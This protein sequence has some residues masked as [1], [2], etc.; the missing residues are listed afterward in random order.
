MGK[1]KKVVLA[2][3]GGLDTS[4]IFRGLK[5]ITVTARLLPFVQMSV[6]RVSLT[7]LRKGQRRAEL[8]SF[9]LKI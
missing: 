4:I 7:D 9:T 6:R 1:I 5:K 2:Y 3:S 8:Q